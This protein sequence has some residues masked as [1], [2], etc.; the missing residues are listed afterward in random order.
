MVKINEAEKPKVEAT[1]ASQKALGK[2][3]LHWLGGQGLA[4]VQAPKPQGLGGESMVA[5]ALVVEGEEE[6]MTV[7]EG[8]CFLWRYDRGIVS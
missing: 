6:K 5:G 2:G 4:G 1:Q 3:A 8:G 7:M